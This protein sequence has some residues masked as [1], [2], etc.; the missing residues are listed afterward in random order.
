MNDKAG[1][2]TCHR[3]L[4]M[5]ATAV[6]ILASCSAS[7]RGTTQAT[8][9]TTISAPRVAAVTPDQAARLAVTVPFEADRGALVVTARRILSAVSADQAL[10]VVHAVLETT[11]GGSQVDFVLPAHELLA[12]AVT[13]ARGLG[14][15]ALDRVSGWVFIFQLPAASCAATMTRPPPPPTWASGLTAV[16]VTSPDADRAVTY[17]GAGTGVCGPDSQTPVAYLGRRLSG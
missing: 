11:Y 10:Q 15:P 4:V 8:V 13:L 3:T 2:R 12:G 16:I 1:P 9:T 14:A 17:Q 6:G 5:V 7:S